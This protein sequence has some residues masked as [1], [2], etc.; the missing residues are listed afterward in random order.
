MGDSNNFVPFT[1]VSLQFT[2]VTVAF[3]ITPAHKIQG[4]R[5]RPWTCT[6]CCT[7]SHNN[8][9][10]VWRTGPESARILGTVYNPKE[11]RAMMR[12]RKRKSE[13]KEEKPKSRRRGWKKKRSSI[14]RFKFIK[15]DAPV[16]QSVLQTPTSR[17]SGSR[18]G[19]VIVLCVL[20][21][22]TL[23]QLCPSPPQE[24]K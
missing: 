6:V 1:R 16:L 17:G 18:P 19:Q 23:L 11:E 24:Y 14:I 8:A 4:R 21:K 22:D 9:L 2:S 3:S 12:E 5:T 10:R 15:G 13:S 7:I 20:G